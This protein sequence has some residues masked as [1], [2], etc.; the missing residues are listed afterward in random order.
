MEIGEAILAYEIDLKA[1]NKFPATIRWYTHKLRY[2]AEWLNESKAISEVGGVESKHVKA[3]LL[4]L[5]NAE[6]AVDGV[7]Q[8]RKG[9]AS[10]LTAHGYAQVIKTFFGW[11]TRN[12]HLDSNPCRDMRM[13][14]VEKYVIQAFTA[15]DVRR[16]LKAAQQRRHAARDYALV[17]LLYDTAIRAGELTGLKLEDIDFEGGWLRANGKGEGENGAS[18]TGVKAGAVALLQRLPP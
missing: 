1:E 11:L 8:Y 6:S 18:G 17:L 14:K 7:R 16:M 2:F 10:S 4:R 9:K 13:P 12:G 5:S 3:F 15:E